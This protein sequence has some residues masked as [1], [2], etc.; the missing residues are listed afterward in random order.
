M[1]LLRSFWVCALKAAAGLRPG[2]GNLACERDA[3]VGEV[4]PCP[5]SVEDGRRRM[6]LL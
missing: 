2:P 1:G 3:R 6:T 5:Q 4:P